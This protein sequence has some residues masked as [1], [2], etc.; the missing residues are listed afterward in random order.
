MAARAIRLAKTIAVFLQIRGRGVEGP[1][2]IEFYVPQS[3]RNP[4]KW[5]AASERGK[6]FA[7]GA[8]TRESA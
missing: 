1:K 2:V 7:F 3:F 4:Q 5:V 8:H 6:L